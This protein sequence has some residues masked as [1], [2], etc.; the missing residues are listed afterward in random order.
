M[1]QE[2]YFRADWFCKH[3]HDR[4]ED[5]RAIRQQ[6]FARAERTNDGRVVPVLE[7]DNHVYARPPPRTVAD[8]RYDLVTGSLRLR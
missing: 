5:R 4:I 8:L 6:A 2:T 7:C 1:S 3:N